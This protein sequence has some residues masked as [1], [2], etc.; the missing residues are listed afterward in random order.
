MGSQL[1]LPPLGSFAHSAKAPTAGQAQSGDTSLF[2][3][4]T[5]SGDPGL[6]ANIKIAER[7]L[8]QLTKEENKRKAEEKREAEEKKKTEEEKKVKLEKEK[9]DVEKL[10]LEEL[11]NK[12]S[13]VSPEL[14]DHLKKLIEKKEKEAKE[15]KC[16]D[17]DNK[18]ANGKECQCNGDDTCENGKGKGGSKGGGMGDEQGSD[19]ELKSICEEAA[20]DCEKIAKEKGDKIKSCK[21]GIVSEWTKLA[22]YC[23]DQASKTT[24]SE[25]D[26]RSPNVRGVCNS[27][28]KICLDL[29]LKG[30]KNKAKEVYVHECVHACEFKETGTSDEKDSYDIDKEYAQA[31]GAGG[32]R[33]SGAKGR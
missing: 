32:G 6:E 11:K 27:R 15:K 13:S 23:K 33:G 19:A 7:K 20:N 30:Q 8:E 17:G 1:K 21:K 12:E 5:P 3:T 2:K 31:I 18:D 4:S 29:S 16:K 24:W 9:S 25:L 10:S 22:K 26:S 14:K 28:G